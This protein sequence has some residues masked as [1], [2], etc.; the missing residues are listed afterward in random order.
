MADDCISWMLSSTKWLHPSLLVQ[1]CCLKCQQS[2][3]HP[4]SVHQHCPWAR[5]LCWEPMSSLPKRKRHNWHDCCSTPTTREMWRAKPTTLQMDTS[6][7]CVSFMKE[8]PPQWLR[9]VRIP[10]HSVPVTNGVKRHMSQLPHF[11][12]WYSQ[13]C[14]LTH[15]LKGIL[16]SNEDTEQ[17][18]ICSTCVASQSHYKLIWKKQC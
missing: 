1:C 17:T 15:S 7:W 5:T 2:Y 14:L 18:V 16:E 4:S 6:P 13:L 12:A 8:W 9:S 11:S 10:N 3:S